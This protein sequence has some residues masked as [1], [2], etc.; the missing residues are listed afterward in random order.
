[1]ND[2]PANTSIRIEGFCG[3]RWKVDL[4]LESKNPPQLLVHA[5][6][7][8]LFGE[9]D[10]RSVRTGN[11]RGTHVDEP[12]IDTNMSYKMYIITLKKKK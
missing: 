3:E 9:V 6:G 7:G 10:T 11:A 5:H 12:E 1:M 4:E 2:T 8:R